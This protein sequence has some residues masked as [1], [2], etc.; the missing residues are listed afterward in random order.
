MKLFI[1]IGLLLLL[2]LASCVTIMQTLVNHEN[3]VT[4]DRLRGQWVGSDLKTIG[5]KSLMDSKYKDD[6]LN[7]LKKQ[8]ISRADSLFFSKL[9]IISFHENNLEY[10]WIGGVAKIN[11]QYY[12]NLSAEECLDDLNE[13][14]YDLSG[15]LGTSSIAKLQW[16]S[17]NSLSLNFLNGDRIREIILKGNARVSYEYDPLF[18]TFVITAS[19]TEL[20]DF[21][22]KYGNNAELYKGGNIINLV[23]K[24]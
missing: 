15:L 23:R 11:D 6:L 4:D 9:Y 19:S 10:S 20:E 2:A 3:I 16:N 13:D 24:R 8:K 5:V 7:G 22:E 18:G 14:G 21:L 12:L 1:T 17:N